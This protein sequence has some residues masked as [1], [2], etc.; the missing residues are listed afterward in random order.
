M[1]LLKR[2]FRKR[3]SS[4]SKFYNDEAQANIPQNLMSIIPWDYRINVYKYNGVELFKKLSYCLPQVFNMVNQPKRDPVII[5]V[6]VE[7][8]KWRGL[9]Y[10]LF[11]N[12][13]VY[14][15]AEMLT[16]QDPQF[17]TTSEGVLYKSPIIIG[18]QLKVGIYATER[19]SLVDAL[20]NT[21]DVPLQLIKYVKADCPKGMFTVVNFS[22]LNPGVREVTCSA[23]VNEIN[24]NSIDFANKWFNDSFCRH[25]K[26]SLKKMSI[27]NLQKYSEQEW[28][29][30]ICS[31]P[32]G[33]FSVHYRI[34]DF[35]KLHNKLFKV[36]QKKYVN[37]TRALLQ[38]FYNHIEALCDNC[39]GSITG[40]T[41]VSVTSFQN[42]SNFS[43][44]DEEFR[45]L[46][47]GICGK[48]NGING[49]CNSDKYIV[50]WNGGGS[51]NEK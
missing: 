18:S 16:N 49:K 48:F 51:I 26:Q 29:E 39:L 13:D 11:R 38:I 50:I 41:F 23:K 15:S 17:E 35:N 31:Q 10:L 7:E 44:G 33:L 37:N 34:K 36:L 47:N 46:V 45:R 1:S 14:Y 25:S 5:L 6:E 19:E 21:V 3:E 20:C 22:G 9:L 27:D 43:G 4:I 42:V 32:D 2:L 28:I 24:L 40:R 8:K 30:N 12:K